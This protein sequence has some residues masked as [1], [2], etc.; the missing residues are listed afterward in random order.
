MR[1][2]VLIVLLLVTQAAG[3]DEVPR[4]GVQPVY[5]VEVADQRYLVTKFTDT[6]RERISKWNLLRFKRG[7]LI[8]T[9]E[10]LD[11]KYPLRLYEPQYRKNKAILDEVPDVR[12]DDQKHPIKH[13]VEQFG[14]AANTL[15]SFFLLFVGR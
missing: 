8:R 1:F 3:A 10:L 6:S 7:E 9:Y 4:T 5:A 2:L 12:P 13:G 15:V 11:S 14:P